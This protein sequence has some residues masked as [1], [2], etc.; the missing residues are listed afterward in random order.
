MNLDLEQARIKALPEDGFYIA[1]FITESEEE[2]LTQ[3]V[4]LRL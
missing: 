3:K 4:L 1:D 2:I